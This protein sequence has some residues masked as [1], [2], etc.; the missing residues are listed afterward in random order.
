[1]RA[2]ELGF[3]WLLARYLQLTRQDFG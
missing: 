2:L 1:L 3:L